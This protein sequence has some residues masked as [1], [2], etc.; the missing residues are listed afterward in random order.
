MKSG[1]IL[2][3]G[4]TNSGKSTLLNQVV[5]KRVSLVSRKKQSTTFNLKSVINISEAELILQDTPGIFFSAKKISNKMSNSAITE[6]DSAVVIYLVIDASKKFETS[7]KKI[8][9]TLKEKIEYQK[10]FL[11]LNKID[12]IK[13][14]K[15]LIKIE[16]YKNYTEID[17][18]FPI[19]AKEGTGINNLLTSSIQY[20]PKKKNKYSKTKE[21]LINKDLFY[22]EI[23]R[24]KI[25]DKIHKEIPYQCRVIT[26]KIEKSKNQIR[27]H[28]VIKVS[29]KSHKN[30]IIGK[31]GS[32]LKEIGALSRREISN[33][34]NKKIHLFLFVKVDTA[35]KL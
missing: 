8:I 12:K 30:I 35:K 1:N 27:I 28:Q 17:A 31:K 29:K 13:K 6:I 18:I 11:I 34:E 20:L 33:F 7:F 32:T 23:T 21:P 25:Y 2:L 15:T 3:I 19:S 26:E 14:S 16:E 4:P 9:N 10:I 22:S 5:G 24:E